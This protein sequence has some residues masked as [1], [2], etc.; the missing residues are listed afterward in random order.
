MPGPAKGATF[1]IVV[2]HGPTLDNEEGAAVLLR[3][4]GAEVR[5]LDLWDDFSRA[6]DHDDGLDHGSPRAIVFEAGDRPDLAVASLRAARREARLQDVPALIQLPTRQVAR[7]EPS[8]GFDDFIVSPY[9]PAE[10]YARIRALEW[11]R[12]EFSTEE[13]FKIGALVI[14]RAAHEVTLEGR[15]VAL[16]AKEFAL[17]A[18]LA[19]NRGRVFS[20]DVLLARVWGARYEG[21][22]RTV[23][24]HVRRLRAKLGDGLPLET[25]RGAGY[26][27][28]APRGEDLSEER[29]P[30]GKAREARDAKGSRSR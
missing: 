9:D 24:I 17:V 11:K 23:D 14:D 2:G 18:Y 10:L 7:L 27:L 5:A 6:L 12:S 26:K 25:M 20:R 16:T 1:V 3:Q 28:R 13:R 21:G 19:A 22:A 30:R 4:L 8:S 15:R 29:E